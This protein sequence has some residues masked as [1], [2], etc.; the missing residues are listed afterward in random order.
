MHTGKL[1][2]PH[3]KITAGKEMYIVEKQQHRCAPTLHRLGIKA[4]VQDADKGSAV[5][6]IKS[7]L[8][9][10]RSIAER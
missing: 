6:L 1:K 2:R 4:K 3:S 9:A 5:I 7:L 10:N 8:C